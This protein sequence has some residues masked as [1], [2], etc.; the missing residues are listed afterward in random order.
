M[1]TDLQAVMC[2][3]GTIKAVKTIFQIYLNLFIHSSSREITV[4]IR[5]SSKTIAF[6]LSQP[7]TRSLCFVFSLSLSL[8]HVLM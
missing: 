1:I 2:T 4:A 7:Q 3:N 8:S 6:T 5:K